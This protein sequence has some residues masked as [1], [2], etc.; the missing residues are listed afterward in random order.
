MESGVRAIMMALG[1]KSSLVVY[2]G[3][4]SFCR[5]FVR[6]ARTWTGTAV[7]YTPYQQAGERIHGIPS[8][9]FAAAVHLLEPNGEVYKGAHAVFRLL[10]H[11]P[12]WR[13]LLWC[14]RHLPGFA[15]A[16]ERV[17]RGVARHRRCLSACQLG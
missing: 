8:A 11:H 1:D 2:D 3:D 9:D 4:C 16:S 10:A 7:S 5:D 6:R 17:Y 12:A 13:W 15:A 14:Y